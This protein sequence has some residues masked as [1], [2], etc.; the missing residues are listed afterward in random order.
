MKTQDLTGLRVPVNQRAIAQQ[1][2]QQLAD[3][4]TVNTGE[5]WVAIVEQYT[6]S[7]RRS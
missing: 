7:V 5:P 4:M 6:P 1:L 3:K 2:A